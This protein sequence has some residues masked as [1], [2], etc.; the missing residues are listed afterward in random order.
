MRF[1]AEQRRRGYSAGLPYRKHKMATATFTVASWEYQ[2][3]VY[4][5]DANYLTAHDGEG[6][7]EGGTVDGLGQILNGGVYSLYRLGV[8]FDTSSLPDNAT[9]TSA[10][11]RL[12][13]QN[14]DTTGGEFNAT[15]V[16]GADLNTPIAGE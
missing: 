8:V 1:R 7:T 4:G 11:L 14:K 6:A 15:V 16:N 13:C 12:Y 3:S 9:I 5:Q 2:E 10:T